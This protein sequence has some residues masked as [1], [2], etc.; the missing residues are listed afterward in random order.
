MNNK[1]ERV[2]HVTSSSSWKLLATQAKVKTYLKE[3]A[4][5]KKLGRGLGTELSAK[6][7]TWGKFIESRVFDLL[8]LEYSLVSTDTIQHKSIA[9][10]SGTPDGTTKD[11]VIDIKCPF[12]MKSF[13]EL[14]EIIESND[15]EKFKD[16]K[17]EYYW[18]LVSNSVLTE[19]THAELIV[20]CPYKS[21]LVDIRIACDNYDG[22]DQNKLM[23]IALASDDE[24]PYLIDGGNY[25]NINIFKF[26][27]PQSDKDLL[28]QKIQSIEI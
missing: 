27:V 24:L 16:D 8:G 12:T 28:T 1:I 14:V 5:E 3:L 25:K 19:K 13:C 2:A 4:Y 11:S 15:I 18:Q 23:F 17:P 26:E 6:P 22:A 21:E 9:H 20:Y 7:T 10:W